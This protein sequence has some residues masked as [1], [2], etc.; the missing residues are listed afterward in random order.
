MQNLAAL[1]LMALAWLKLSPRGTSSF[2]KKWTTLEYYSQVARFSV[3][4]WF[5]SCSS[6]A[7]SVCSSPEFGPMQ[8][9]SNK[10]QF[11]SVISLANPW[12]LTSLVGFTSM[13]NSMNFAIHLSLF[14]S[15]YGWVK[16]SFT[17]AEGTYATLWN[18][19]YKFWMPLNI[20]WEH[21][22]VFQ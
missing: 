11:S 1:S 22:L 15:I 9:M 3:K 10:L 4:S 6:A 21:K 2:C 16:T 18:A 5:C 14:P 19:K 7:S 12:P 20:L 8:L 17:E 13:L